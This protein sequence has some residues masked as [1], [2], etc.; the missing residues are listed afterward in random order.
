[1]GISYL[2]LPEWDNKLP[3]NTQASRILLGSSGILWFGGKMKQELDSEES[4]YYAIGLWT[5]GMF[6]SVGAILD[7]II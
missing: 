3:P 1:M 7:G 4:D 2:D 6:A 5:F